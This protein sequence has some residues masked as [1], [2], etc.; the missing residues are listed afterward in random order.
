MIFQNPPK[1]GVTSPALPS[2]HSHLR[3]IYSTAAAVL[4]DH[5]TVLASPIIWGLLLKLV[6][7]NSLS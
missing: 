4:G 2:E 6:F 5:P 7:T 1:A 3:L